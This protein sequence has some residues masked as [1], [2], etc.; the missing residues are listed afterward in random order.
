M[1]KD[2]DGSLCPAQDLQASSGRGQSSGTPPLPH[3]PHTV[4]SSL[5]PSQTPGLSQQG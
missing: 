5:G 1:G 4:P 2:P 3:L